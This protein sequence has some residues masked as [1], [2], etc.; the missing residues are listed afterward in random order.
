MSFSTQEPPSTLLRYSIAGCSEY[1]G[2][3]DGSH[4]MVDRPT[5]Q[6]SRWSGALHMPGVK[7]WILL[8]LDELSVLS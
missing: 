1:S 5:D 6:S 7:Q 2:R 3:Y 4:I 8:R